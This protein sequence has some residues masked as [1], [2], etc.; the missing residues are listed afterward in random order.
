MVV[1]KWLGEA[2]VLSFKKGLLSSY[3]MLTSMCGRGLTS[4]IEA[5]WLIGKHIQ[6]KHIPECIHEEPPEK[7][8]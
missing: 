4:F 2:A 7:V 6:M 3:Y 8:V 1:A 5:H